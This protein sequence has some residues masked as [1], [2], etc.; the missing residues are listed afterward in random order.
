[1][2]SFE[3]ISLNDYEKLVN[4]EKKY[5]IRPKYLQHQKF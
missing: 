3:T 1:M 2:T 4:N 5:L